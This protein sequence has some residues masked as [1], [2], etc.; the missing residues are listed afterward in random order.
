MKKNLKLNDEPR[1]LVVKSS[2][3]RND[4]NKSV[5]VKPA[6]SPSIEPTPVK[7][8]KEITT[9]EEKRTNK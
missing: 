7:L 5:N 9:T 2:E 4:E 6:S 8:G 1:N 3:K